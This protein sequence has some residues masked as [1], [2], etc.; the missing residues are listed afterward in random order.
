M[1]IQVRGRMRTDF[2]D[3]NWLASPAHVQVGGFTARID[4][5]LR[6]EELPGFRVAL[7][8][9]HA[10]VRRKRH[11]VLHGA[12]CRVFLPQALC[13]SPVPW[14]II[15]RSG[16]P[17]TSRS[18]SDSPSW[19]TDDRLLGATLGATRTDDLEICRTDLNGRARRAAGRTAL[20][21]PGDRLG[22][23]GPDVPS[24]YRV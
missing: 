23:Y 11:S 6:V 24:V 8:R 22:A 15:L 16:T 14:L 12:H 13:R 7:E 9:I 3:G 5:G 18:R 4:A 19:D 20:N 1:L 10:D 2:W 17:F 21:D